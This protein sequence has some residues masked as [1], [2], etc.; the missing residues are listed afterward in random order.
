[1]H[2]NKTQKWTKHNKCTTTNTFAWL[3]SVWMWLCMS[4]RHVS[5]LPCSCFVRASLLAVTSSWNTSMGREIILMTESFRLCHRVI[6][7]L[8]V[9]LPLP[10]SLSHSLTHSIV[11]SVSCLFFL[12]YFCLSYFCLLVGLLIPWFR[13]FFNSFVRSLVLFFCAI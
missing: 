3:I 1:M 9:S 10:L 4:A 11:L 12:A 8:S 2:N 7:S 5:L 6:F 13:S